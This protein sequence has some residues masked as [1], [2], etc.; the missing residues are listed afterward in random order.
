MAGAVPVDHRV[1]EVVLEVV[2][3]VPVDVAQAV[4]EVVAARAAA[5]GPEVVEA[6]VRVDGSVV[7]NIVV[8]RPTMSNTSITRTIG[9]CARC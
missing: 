5:D 8:S 9:N 4:P 6:A 7:R 3:E 2:R 1:A